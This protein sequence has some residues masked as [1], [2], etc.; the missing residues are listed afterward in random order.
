MF[1]FH[2]DSDAVWLKTVHQGLRNLGGEVFLN[3]QAPRKNVYNARDFGQTDHFAIRNVS[4]VGPTNEWK[5]VMFAHRIKLDVFDQN[6]LA[7]FRI[8][9]GVVNDLFDALAITL[10]E[11]FH[12]PRRAGRR[13]YQTLSRRIFPDRIEQVAIDFS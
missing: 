7:R 13:F 12:C 8:E 11:K 10:R 3:L 5:Q 9:D 1:C 4:H 6:N 2:Y